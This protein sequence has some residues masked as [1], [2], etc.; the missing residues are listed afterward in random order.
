V[1]RAILISVALAGTFAVVGC[2]EPTSSP[3]NTFQELAACKVKSMELYRP[4]DDDLNSSVSPAM[5]YI[6][7]CMEAK[8][9]SVTS[10]CASDPARS[11][12]SQCWTPMSPQ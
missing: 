12:V 9:Y 10:D 4:S 2:S 3:K 1:R 6:D 8:G 11:D 5:R 7:A